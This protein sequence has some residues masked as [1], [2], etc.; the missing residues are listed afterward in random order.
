MSKKTKKEALSVLAALENIN[1]VKTTEGSIFTLDTS[2]SFEN[3][4]G[5]SV[6]SVNTVGSALSLFTAAT[7]LAVGQYGQELAKENEDSVASVSADIEVGTHFKVNHRF[8]S[9]E[10]ID[11]EVN[12]NVLRSALTVNLDLE[13]A[14]TDVRNRVSNSEFE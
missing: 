12:E 2:E 4:T 7:G 3:V 11:G 10:T 13:G 5:V 1:S 14:L 9:S 8:L 6:D